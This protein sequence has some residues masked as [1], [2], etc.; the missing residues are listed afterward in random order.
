MIN[1]KPSYR[2]QSLS[3]IIPVRNVENMIEGVL[4]QL[5]EG[6]RGNRVNF[7]ILDNRSTDRTQQKVNS[8]IAIFQRDPNYTFDFVLNSE[9]LG[10]GGSLKKGLRMAKASNSDWI[11]VAHGDDQANWSA[12][13]K[14]MT[15]TASYSNHDLIITSRFMPGS[16]VENYSTQRKIGNYVFRSLTN[17]LLKTDMSDP[18]AAIL[19]IK[20]ETLDLVW[21]ISLREDYLFHPGL[22]IIFYKSNLKISEIPMNWKDAS[23][24]GEIKLIRYGLNLFTFLL[25]VYA[26]KTFFKLDWVDSVAK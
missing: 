2:S 5:I 4:Q 13:T 18:G 3:V 11:V 16:N 26:R 20:K 24:P 12:I 17:M 8:A 14:T 7:I 1:A 10:Y 23:H 25:R 19:M 22:N 9:N 21:I 15:Q 6:L